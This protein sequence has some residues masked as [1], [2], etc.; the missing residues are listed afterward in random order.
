LY[1][2]LIQG[3]VTEDIAQYSFE[4]KG[5]NF[6]LVDT[7]GFDDSDRLDEDIFRDLAKWTEKSYRAGQRL[8]GLIYLH[9]INVNRTRGSEARNLRMFKKLCGEDN[10][11]NVILGLTYCDQEQD[12][13]IARRVQELTDTSN[14]W[15]DMIAQG[16]RVELISLDH[17]DCRNLVFGLAQK[18]KVT[19]KIQSELVY[20]GLKLDQTEAA[21]TIVHKQELDEIRTK[22]RIE[23]AEMKSEYRI[24]MRKASEA[25]DKEMASMKR[26]YELRRQEQEKEAQLL[27]ERIRLNEELE[28]KERLRRDEERAEE[29]AQAAELQQMEENNRQTRLENDRLEHIKDLQTLCYNRY[30]GFEQD[31]WTTVEAWKHY[32]LVKQGFKYMNGQYEIFVRQYAISF[33]ARCLNNLAPN[34]TFH[35]KSPIA[36]PYSLLRSAELIIS[37]SLC[38][39]PKRS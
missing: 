16:S 18:D 12:Q 13:E 17:I 21:Q 35:S 33:C 15:G 11:A 14:W 10:F 7:P 38:R 24:R 3:T 31:E 23:L 8:N 6:T 4:Y 30:V 37:V 27:Q 29:E 39:L 2:S 22:E 26:R 9:P 25:Y 5:K 34:G 32:G 1:T 19:L 28:H 20:D 36:I